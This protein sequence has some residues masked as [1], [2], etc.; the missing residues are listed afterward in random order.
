MLEPRRP[1]SMLASRQGQMPMRSAFGQGMCQK[2][3]I[4]A[5]GRRSRIMLRREGEVVVLHEHD[6]VVAVDL[7]ADGVGELAVHADVL[8]PVFGTELPAAH[9]RR[10]RAA[11]SPSF[12]KP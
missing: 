9:A 12:E 8:L 3:M 10:G 7:A 5:R 11:Q 6:G 2:V 1:A 4:V